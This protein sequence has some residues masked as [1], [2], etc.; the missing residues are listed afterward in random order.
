ML[1]GSAAAKAGISAKDVL[2]AVD[3]IKADGKALSKL[4][5]AQVDTP[6]RCHL[7]R[8][9]VLLTVDILPNGAKDANGEHDANT[10]NVWQHVSLH[11]ASDNDN[12]NDKA[13]K[14]WQTWLGALN[15]T[16]NTAAK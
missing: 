5:A 1:R 13:E 8:R 4:A 2:I 16:P 14:P 15:N 11:H 9:D 12:D 7:F 10:D 6:I 3:G